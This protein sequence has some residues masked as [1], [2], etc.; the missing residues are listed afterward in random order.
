MH[1]MV[2]IMGVVITM[3]EKCM[4]VLTLP[5]GISIRQAKR[6][7]KTLSKT[8]GVQLSKAQDLIAFKHGRSSW[9]TLINQLATQ[10]SLALSFNDH[11]QILSFPEGKTLSI[12]EGR[13]GFGKTVL[14]IEIASQWVN[15]GYPII[16]LSTGF[17]QNELLQLKQL[18]SSSLSQNLL[19]VLDFNDPKLDL[20]SFK[21]DGAILLIDEFETLLRVFPSVL[22]NDILKTSLHTI[23][24]VQ[25]YENMKTNL[26]GSVIHINNKQMFLLGD[27]S[28]RFG[29]TLRTE[30]NKLIEC[31]FVSEIKQQTFNLQL[32]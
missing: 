19:K 29:I 28:D 3:K 15:A 10:K 1:C 21:L 18:S 32:E 6:D 26:G 8:N 22:I 7:A 16:Y 4:S 12:I 25:S 24:S 9:A 5:S 27:S 2:M 17:S 13:V 23:I 30:R 14:L 31:Q 11:K 20:V